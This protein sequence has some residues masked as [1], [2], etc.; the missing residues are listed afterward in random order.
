[1]EARGDAAQTAEQVRTWA[2]TQLAALESRIAACRC[3]AG[4]GGGRVIEGVLRLTAAGLFDAGWATERGL[5]SALVAHGAYAEGVTGAEAEAA[6]CTVG[7]VAR[8]GS[9][10]SWWEVL[11]FAR[12]QCALDDDEQLWWWKPIRL[13]APAPRSSADPES[14]DGGVPSLWQLATWLTTRDRAPRVLAAI[15]YASDDPYDRDA[16]AKFA[17]RDIPQLQGRWRPL[18]GALHGLDS[19]AATSTSRSLRTN[20]T[21]KP[22]ARAIAHFCA[23][24]LELGAPSSAE[25][26][27]RRSR[28]APVPRNELRFAAS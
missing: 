10:R 18:L 13:K 5:T 22:A 11:G 20:H 26:L 14:R 3:A 1:M 12:Q 27:C 17:E 4:F 15:T 24:I 16:L 23:F 19:A 2:G 28:R 25:H 8:Q 9:G 21:I 6:L 7:R